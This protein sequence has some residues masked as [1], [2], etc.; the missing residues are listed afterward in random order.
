MTRTPSFKALRA[1]LH[2]AIGISFISLIINTL[3]ASGATRVAIY[4]GPWE[5]TRTWSGNT[6]PVAGDSVII[7]FGNTI[8][9]NNPVAFDKE[10]APMQIFIYGKLEFKTT[11]GVHL[12]CGSWVS[13]FEKGSV[14]TPAS[15]NADLITLC[16]TP[17]VI[18]ETGT[19]Q[20]NKSWG[21]PP[22]ASVKNATIR[23]TDLYTKRTESNNAFVCWNAEQASATHFFTL[24]RSNDG[25]KFEPVGSIKGG[26]PE[27]T[28]QTHNYTDAH[29]YTVKS[30][31]RVKQTSY[32]GSVSYSQTVI[33]EAAKD[34]AQGSKVRM[35]G[36]THEIE[37]MIT[38][39][40]IG[41]QWKVIILDENGNMMSRTIHIVN[42]VPGSIYIKN[43]GLPRGDY[44]VLIKKP[45][46]VGEYTLTVGK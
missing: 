29:P 4:S 18:S 40:P 34:P 22:A 25:I 9:V 1:Q 19:V 30:W 12:P 14:V 17:I 16:G 35:N 46:G 36:L 32:D 33:L 41:E 10:S 43:P 45:F 20:G 23:W 37:V 5:S 42:N 38:D 7:P 39:A 28:I 15:K 24:E 3:P 11:S 31:Y 27:A 44:K 2:L 26:G 21:N 13:V 8:L 6:L